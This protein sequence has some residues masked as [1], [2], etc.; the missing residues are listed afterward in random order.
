M[1]SKAMNTV[2]G[3]ILGLAFTL[4][5]QASNTVDAIEAVNIQFELG[6]AEAD[7]ALIGGVYTQ[8]GQL[9]PPNSPIVSG[10]DNILSCWQ[11]ALDMGVAKAEL[12]TIELDEQGDTAVEVGLFTLS[13][14]DGTVID[15]G[16]YIVIW[17]NTSDGWK[18]HRDMWSSERP[19][20]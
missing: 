1:N 17:K 5:A 13:T 3:L 10:M 2:K 18:Y 11:G 20:S 12:D 15:T 8:D 14:A 9:M 7:A 6:F 4:N 19:A 16:K